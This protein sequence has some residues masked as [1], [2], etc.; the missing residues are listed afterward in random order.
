MLPVYGHSYSTAASEEELALQ[1]HFSQLCMVPPSITWFLR[2]SEH[3]YTWLDASDDDEEEAQNLHEELVVR[4]LK[5]RCQQ[6]VQANSMQRR[7]SLSPER[8]SAAKPRRNYR[9]LPVRDDGQ[10]EY[11]VIL[12][13]GVYRTILLNVGEVEDGPNFRQKSYLYPVGF[14]SKHK[15]FAFDTEASLER[16]KRFEIS[17]EGN[18]AASVDEGESDVQT[19]ETVQLLE[20]DSDLSSLW[21]R[22][23][24]RFRSDLIEK[25]NSDFPF[26]ETFFGLDHES[27][28][29]HLREQATPMPSQE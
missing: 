9:H 13:R 19:S 6:M 16:P 18:P 10:I 12:G 5:E 20:S 14:H 22:F 11:P 26:P 4:E 3:E 23:R 27:L 7:R 8:K 24:D 25:L 15:Y 1:H 17:V 2:L 28:A 29:K 21:A